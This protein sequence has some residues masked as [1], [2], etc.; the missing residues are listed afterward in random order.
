M[1]TYSLGPSS[2][3]PLLLILSF[4]PPKGPICSSLSDSRFLALSLSFP[5]CTRIPSTSASY[6]TGSL[7]R[8]RNAMSL[9]C[10]LMEFLSSWPKFPW[11]GLTHSA[12]ANLSLASGCWVPGPRL[13]PRVTQHSSCKAHGAT[14]RSA[15]LCTSHSRKHATTI[16]SLS[17]KNFK[18]SKMSSGTIRTLLMKGMCIAL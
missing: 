4:L 18:S 12:G 11:L 3:S 1:T 7:Q 17:W 15:S 9:N 6:H 10:E 8:K 13:Q 16:Q 2:P 14:Q 5:I